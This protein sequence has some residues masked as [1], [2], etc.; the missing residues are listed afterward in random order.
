[1][2]QF[3]II[4]PGASRKLDFQPLR[5]DATTQFFPGQTYP[6]LAHRPAGVS[7][8]RGSVHKAWISLALKTPTT[9]V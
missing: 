5:E 1:M 9:E 8:A 4:A 2:G 3:L 7:E 6:P